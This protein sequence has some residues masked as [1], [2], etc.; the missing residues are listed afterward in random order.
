[1]SRFFSL[2]FSFLVLLVGQVSSESFPKTIDAGG[3]RTLTL[4]R[5]PRRIV[6]LTI[7][8]DEILSGLVDP[9]RIQ[10]VSYLAA[11]PTLSNV[12]PW[13]EK[14]PRKIHPDIEQI[15][16][17]EP[18][19][20]FLLENSRAE[21]LQA[22]LDARVPVVLIHIQNSIQD[23]KND[24]LKIGNSVGEEAKAKE[25]IAQMDK[26]LEA[27]AAKMQAVK[28]RPRVMVYH[29]SGSTAGKVRTIDEII[30]LAGGINISAEK[31]VVG[32]V[33]ISEEKIVEWNPEVLLLS[34]YSPGKETFADAVRANPAF[35]TVSA[36]KN[37]R[38]CVIPG[39]YFLST[40]QYIVEGVEAIAQALHP[41]LFTP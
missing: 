4:E 23:V 34:G 25:L 19:I 17:L 40:S 18:D 27:I 20:V 36:M 15:L 7:S 9:S 33:K 22:L 37:N 29:F 2:A 26:K 16:A 41:E 5:P 30:R 14:I 12:L 3:G 38:V 28:K 13:A 24:I 11:E 31:G 6:S 10:A 32:T 1:M 39:K 21:I 8:V 35:Q